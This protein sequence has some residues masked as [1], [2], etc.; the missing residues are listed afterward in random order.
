M[1]I[2]EK[3]DRLFGKVKNFEADDGR[4]YPLGAV[5]GSTSPGSLLGEMVDRFNIKMLDIPTTRWIKLPDEIGI[6]PLP[7]LSGDILVAIEG[8]GQATEPYREALSALDYTNPVLAPIKRMTCLEFLANNNLLD[9]YPIFFL[10]FTAFGY[11]EMSK[12]PA[13]YLLRTYNAESLFGV[14]VGG[15]E[16]A[17]KVI[18][19]QQMLEAM[20]EGI[21]THLETNVVG[22]EHCDVVDAGDEGY[23]TLNC[24][25]EGGRSGKKNTKGAKRK[26]GKRKKGGGKKLKKGSPSGS[27][28]GTNGM[29]ILHTDTGEDFL[30]SNVVVAFPPLGDMTFLPFTADQLSIFRNLRTVD[31][32]SALS[33]T[34]RDASFVNLSPILP[35]ETLPLEPLVYGNIFPE[36]LSYTTSF[37]QDTSSSSSDAEIKDA[38]LDAD[39]AAFSSTDPAL[40]AFNH[41]DDYFP[42]VPVED[43]PGFFEAVEE[44]QGENN[45]YFVGS[46]NSMELMRDTL[47]SGYL[48]AKKE[49]T[50]ED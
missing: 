30:C 6:F 21:E 35:N 15:S 50:E 19:F 20:V 27:D 16:V 37:I 3:D 8:Y 2:L 22:I 46:F 5:L 44:L 10:L 18:F 48:F 13:L 12:V 33:T 38:M 42:Y 4:Q 43:M 9:L 49:F 36:G 14:A 47:Q 26:K 32:Y 39:K 11:G 17:T 29:N 23:R 40:L 31:Y 45:V 28:D 25:L 7:P 41:W 1:R 24:R 34:E